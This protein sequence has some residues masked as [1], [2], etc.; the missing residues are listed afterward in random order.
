MSL[1]YFYVP[2]FDKDHPEMDLDEDNSRHIVQVLRMEPGEDLCLTDGKGTLAAASIVEAHKKK[3]RIAV[4][5][6]AACAGACHSRDDACVPV[7][8][9]DGTVF[10]IRQIQATVASPR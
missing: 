4:R 7:H 6:V 2:S 8:P 10:R 3:C 5:S 9:A 1:P